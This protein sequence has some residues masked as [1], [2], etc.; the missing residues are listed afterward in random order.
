MVAAAASIKGFGRRI[1]T[2]PHPTASGMTYVSAAGEE[3][4]PGKLTA[5][6]TYRLREDDSLEIAYDATTTRTDS[7]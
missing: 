5:H 2:A 4:Y 1:A 7:R 3:G 6:V